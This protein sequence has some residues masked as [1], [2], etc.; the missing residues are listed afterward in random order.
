MGDGWCRC[1]RHSRQAGV[2]G[3]LA[4]HLP[5]TAGDYRIEPDTREKPLTAYALVK[6]FFALVGSCAPGAI[7]TPAPA[8]GGRTPNRSRLS[9]GK[10]ASRKPSQPSL[11]ATGARGSFHGTFHGCDLPVSYGIE[12]DARCGAA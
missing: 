12:V 7:R 5:W 11:L 4:A 6:G 9:P 10:S 2:A 3:N 1:P 8:S